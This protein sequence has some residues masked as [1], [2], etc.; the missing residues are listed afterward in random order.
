[1]DFHNSDHHFLLQ[2]R[3]EVMSVGQLANIEADQK[4]ARSFIST[5]LRVFDSIIIHEPASYW[6]FSIL[7]NTDKLWF[8]EFDRLDV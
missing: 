8:E 3:N 7:Y 6:E 1:M 4:I 2:I 5:W